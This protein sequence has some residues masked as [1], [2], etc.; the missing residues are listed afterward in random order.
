MR[1]RLVIGAVTES[2]QD[3]QTVVVTRERR[4]CPGIVVQGTTIVDEQKNDSTSD[5]RRLSR[6]KKVLAKEDL[7]SVDS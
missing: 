5:I 3:W 6:G 4:E 1:K 2:C 7:G